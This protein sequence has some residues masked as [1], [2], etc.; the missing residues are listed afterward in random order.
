MAPGAFVFAMANPNPEV[1]PDVAHKYAAV[2][3]TG[4]SDYPNQIN[5]VLA[6]PGIFAGALQVR[7]SRITEGMKIAAADALADVVGD[8]LARGLRDPVAVRRAGRPGGHRG[9]GR[10]R[11]RGGRRPRADAAVAVRLHGP[12]R[13]PDRGPDGPSPVRV[14]AAG[15]RRLVRPARASAATGGRAR[16]APRGACHTGTWFRRAPARP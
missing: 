11:A 8:E 12:R 14:S 9:G 2:V 15:G 6:F 4:R 1:H 3:A 10:G 16:A 5:N 7:A 13:P